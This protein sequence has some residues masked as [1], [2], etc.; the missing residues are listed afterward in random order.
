MQ[1]AAAF[2]DPA[3]L[4]I[5][6]DRGHSVNGRLEDFEYYGDIG[7]STDT[8]LTA[9]DFNNVRNTLH[10]IERGADYTLSVQYKSDK[11]DQPFGKLMQ[12][13]VIRCC[14]RSNSVQTLAALIDAGYVEGNG[15]DT[16]ILPDLGVF[17]DFMTI[18]PI[19]AAA[20][21]GSVGCVYA[22]ARRG[23]NMGA[24][25]NI[26]DLSMCASILR[27]GNLIWK[28]TFAKQRLWQIY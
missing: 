13:D 20:M 15:E 21:F 5:F 16:T 11:S 18:P 9:I 12:F 19:I 10:L 6:I 7:E 22:L 23:A 25:I 8:I 17:K 14:A 26:D 24:Q 1:F 2:A 4:E 28:T 27:F 3:T